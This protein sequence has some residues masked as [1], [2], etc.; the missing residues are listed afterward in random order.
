MTST[1]TYGWDLERARLEGGEDYGRVVRVLVEAGLLCHAKGIM[2]CPKVSDDPARQAHYAACRL[3]D[4]PH[5]LAEMFAL[6]SP[7]M[8]NTDREFLE[9]Q[10]G[11]YDQFDGN[12]LI[13]DFHRYQAKQHGVDT[14][15]KV[16]LSGLAAYPGDPRAWVAGRGDA[17]RV[18]EERGWGCEGSVKTKADV[19]PPTAKYKV[20]DDLV[21][22]RA[23]ALAEAGAAR[24]GEEAAHEAR[25]QLSGGR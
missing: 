3:D 25:S 20:A 24:P 9:G 17:Q 23:A 19:K 16:Y 10:G 22:A 1:E 8:S 15:G 7:P 12:E 6:A 14:T 2:D 18:L 5:K 21:A 11:C 13:G 4:V